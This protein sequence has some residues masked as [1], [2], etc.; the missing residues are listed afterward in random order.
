MIEINPLSAK[1]LNHSFSTARLCYDLALSN[2]CDPMKAYLCGVFHDIARELPPKTLLTLAKERHIPVNREEEEEPLLLHGDIAAAVMRENYGIHDEEMLNAV[3]RHTVGDREMTVL[4]KIL[5]LA[6][7]TEPLR[8]YGEAATIRSK[9]FYD[10]DGALYDAI[11]GEMAYCAERGLRVH[12]KTA[13]LF[14]NFSKK[15]KLYMTTT[16]KVNIA[17]NAIVEKKGFDLQLLDVAE[18]TTIAQR[19]IICTAKNR[20]QSQAIADEITDELSKQNEKPL[21]VEGYQAGGWI[22]LDYG[23]VIIHVFLPDEQEYYNLARLW[24]DAKVTRFTET[25]EVLP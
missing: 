7:K 23:D 25:G 8:T 2:N 3:R 13:F 11:C 20:T 4:D 5:F 19:F 17:I 6:D 16:E 24:K 21:R 15:E 9:A 12:P 1:R 10:L 18:I 22:L 14:E